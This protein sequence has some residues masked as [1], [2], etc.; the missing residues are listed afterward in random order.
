M[1][2]RQQ[3]PL[4]KPEPSV[5]VL[6]WTLRSCALQLLREQ[7]SP[8]SELSRKPRLPMPAPSGR[9]KLLALQQSGMP[10]PGGPLRPSH[11]TGNMAKPS[12]TWRNSS[13]T[14]FLSACQAALHASPA[15]LKGI[16]VAS[17]HIL[18]G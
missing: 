16:L 7:R 13:Q 8:T 1:S 6:P 18:L 11:S 3:S 10:R 5:P 4:K 12:E 9:L 14:D 17:Y 15:E 2:L